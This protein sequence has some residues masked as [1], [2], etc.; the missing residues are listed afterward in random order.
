M[1]FKVQNIWQKIDTVLQPTV[2]LSRLLPKVSY[3][4]FHTHCL[5]EQCAIR[6]KERTSANLHHQSR[7]KELFLVAMDSPAGQ[8]R[9]HNRSLMSA[10]LGISES[11]TN[12]DMLRVPK[13]CQMKVMLLQMY[14]ANESLCVLR[15]VYKYSESTKITRSVS[16]S[17]RT[18][19]RSTIDYLT[20]IRS[21]AVSFHCINRLNRALGIMETPRNN[22][23]H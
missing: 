17:S 5:L 10:T 12:I 2:R 11:K 14:F 16:A 9:S 6:R 15:T 8:E 18:P 23:E 22:V 13:S 4:H 21:P 1:P 20:S 7:G 19:Q 3:L